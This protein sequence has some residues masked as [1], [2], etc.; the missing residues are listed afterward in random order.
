[1]HSVYSPWI[2]LV[3]FSGQEVETQSNFHFAVYLQQDNDSLAKLL[4]T[5]V[6]SPNSWKIT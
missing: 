4:L 6:R 2:G 3:A 5:F 1:M